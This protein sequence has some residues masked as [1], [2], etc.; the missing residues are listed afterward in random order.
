[1]SQ[2]PAK[3]LDTPSQTNDTYCLT[4]NLVIEFLQHNNPS[5]TSLEYPLG[6][7]GPQ[8]TEGYP[9]EKVKSKHL[10]LIRG[11]HVALIT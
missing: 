2:V 7:W 10:P 11:H 8:A 1:M 9:L 4:P 5:L 3:L 6:R